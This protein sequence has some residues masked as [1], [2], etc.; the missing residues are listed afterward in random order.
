LL[1]QL[2]NF[3]SSCLSL[4]PEQWSPVAGGL[5]QRYVDVSS[6]VP[7]DRMRAS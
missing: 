4:L 2:S 1:R 5:P 3:P 6:F 7:S